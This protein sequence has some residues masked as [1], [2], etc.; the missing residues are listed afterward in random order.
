MIVELT[1]SPELLLLL[2]VVFKRALCPP[3]CAPIA[4][5]EGAQL[6]VVGLADRVATKGNHKEGRECD[7]SSHNGPRE[8]RQ[9]C[10]PG[11][12]NIRLVVKGS[13]YAVL[14]GEIDG[15][16]W[17]TV[18]MLVRPGVK[19]MGLITIGI[20]TEWGEG[21]MEVFVGRHC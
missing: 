13:K 12:T 6:V 8:T 2:F 20:F 10:R 9:V 7:S 4:S 18:M 16:R 19:L 1:L 15:I 14:N 11:G 17:R 21:N 5:K 3:L